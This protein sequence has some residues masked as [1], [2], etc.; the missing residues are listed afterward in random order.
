[1]CVWWSGPRGGVEGRGFRAGVGGAG[2]CI[3]GTQ[4]PR[5]LGAGLN[6]SSQ[7]VEKPPIF[8]PPLCPQMKLIYSF[9]L[10]DG[11]AFLSKCG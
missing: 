8:Q 10:A 2:W 11:Q 9:L 5:R 4:V 6:R 7:T 3:A 1:M